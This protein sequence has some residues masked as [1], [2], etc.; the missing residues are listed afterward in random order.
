MRVVGIFSVALV[1]VALGA[2][3]STPQMDPRAALLQS[4]E[5]ASDAFPWLITDNWA[6]G[7]AYEPASQFH[8]DGV[9][10]YAY[11]GSVFDNGRW[12]L[13]GAA[14]HI[15]MND[16]YA[17]YDG[18]FDG[19]KGSGAMKNEPGNKGTWTLARACGG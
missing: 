14:L 12:S 3:A 13:E 17:D 6:D 11:D 1:S 18:T 19:V 10:V 15:D 8:A 9:L 7:D 5:D 2:C 4:C 16:H